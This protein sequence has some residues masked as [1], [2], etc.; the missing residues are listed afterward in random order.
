MVGTFDDDHVAN[1][2]FHLKLT[3]STERNDDANEADQNSTTKHGTNIESNVS[4]LHACL[5]RVD[6]ERESTLTMIFTKTMCKQT[7]IL[8]QLKQH[9]SERNDG[10]NETE[11]HGLVD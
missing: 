3:S 7:L 2:G 10:T 1:D 11:Q 4:K 6:I 9:D 5:F 8:F